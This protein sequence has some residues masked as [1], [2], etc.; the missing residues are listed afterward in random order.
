MVLVVDVVDAGSST[1]V[2]REGVFRTPKTAWHLGVSVPVDAE[3]GNFGP[4]PAGLEGFGAKDV[5][6]DHFEQMVRLL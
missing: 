5:S 2:G 1:L 3:K 4:G 6:D